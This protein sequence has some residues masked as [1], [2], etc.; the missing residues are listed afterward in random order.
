MKTIQNVFVTNYFNFFLLFLSFLSFLIFIKGLIKTTKNKKAFERTPFLLFLGIFVWGDAV[1]LGLFWSL[2]SFICFLIK[3]Y[4]LFL[5]I[6]SL[7]WTIRSLGEMVYWLNQQF[8]SINRNPPES[9]FGNFIFKNNSIWFA[10]QL[11]WQCIF[12]LSAIFSF[13]FGNFWLKSL[14]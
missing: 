4:L 11:F 3:D 14:K 1:I 8:S 5:F 10:Y 12:I 6:V 7:F 9:L 13:Y 2:V